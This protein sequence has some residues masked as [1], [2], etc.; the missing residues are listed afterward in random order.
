M[1]KIIY[2]NLETNVR[3]TEYGFTRYAQKR[4]FYL[5][6]CDWAEIEWILPLCRTWKLFKKCWKNEIK[7]E[8]SA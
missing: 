1:Y 5:T 3:I 8:K 7:I 4:V 2:I 6:Q